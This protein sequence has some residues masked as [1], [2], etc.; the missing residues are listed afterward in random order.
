M[1]G[2]IKLPS[3][4]RPKAALKPKLPETLAEPQPDIVINEIDV[5]AP[6]SKQDRKVLIAP[7]K[8]FIKFWR[9]W[10]KLNRNERFAFIAGL[11]LI[12]GA[13]AIGWVYFIQPD[14]HPRVVSYFSHH[15]PKPKAPPTA[16]SPL[17]GVA[18]DPV[19]T[20]R[21]VTGIMIENSTEARPQSGL[22]DA[23]VVVEAIAEGGIT[24]FLAL[25]QESTP[26]Y[27]GPVRSLRPYYLDF[28]A[29][30]Q[31]GIVHVGGSPE[32]LARVRNGSYRDLDQ[33]FNSGY[34]T[35]ISARPAPHN[36]YTGFARLDALNQAKGYTSSLFTT[37]PRKT[38][39]K[40]AVPAAKT[41]DISIS[42]ALYNSHYNY[43]PGSNSYL[44]SEAGKPHLN[45]TNANDK[46]GVQLRPKVVIA[47]VMS[48][49]LE[50]DRKHSQYGDVGS[51]PAE[52]FQDGGVIS[53]SWQKA[54]S[55]S[56]ISFMD[57]DGQ[58]VKLNAGQTWITLV[59]AAG[60]VTYKP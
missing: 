46:T 55:D 35:R 19:L 24:R 8:H 60:K 4:K 13:L 47:L 27:I 39:K 54:D 41:I 10:L 12:F 28:A 58:P 16:P 33:F 51:G 17:T 50:A 40:L 44:R 37:W 25:Y 57:A 6:E 49:G 56:Q 38:D 5:L 45:L 15:K 34:F 36:V 53:G 43:D 29:P 20:K 23:G 42:S 2:D 18:V 22:Q 11:L 30:F 14:P 52:I 9:W 48:Y 31:S 32:A 7:H 59:S 3:R 1:Q 21:P 26:Q